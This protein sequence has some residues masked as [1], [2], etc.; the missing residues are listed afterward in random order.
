MKI[1]VNVAICCYPQE[2]QRVDE[3]RRRLQSLERQHFEFKQKIETSPRE[4]QEEL[5]ALARRDSIQLDS[6]RKKF[7]DLEFRQLEIEARIE[8]EKEMLERRLSAEEHE[9]Q[10]R[11]E[12][13]KVSRDPGGEGSWLEA[14]C[15]VN[16][17]KTIWFC[18][19]THFP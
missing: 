5:Q 7:E 15:N 18:Y 19:N 16:L 13:S 12:T 8:E 17:L 2:R 4:E 3:A 10:S 1:D 14:H 11:M 6:E 9:E